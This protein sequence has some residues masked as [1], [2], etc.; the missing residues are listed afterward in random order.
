MMNEVA[1][2]VRPEAATP[3]HSWTE[4]NRQWLIAAIGRLRARIEAGDAERD[5]P[6]DCV[7]TAGLS[8][9]VPALVG[10]AKAFGLSP[11]E[12][13]LL[14]LLAG[15]E[16]DEG[17]R[18][19][20]V[21]AGAGAATRASFSFACAHLIAP[22]WDALSPDAPLRHWRMM[23]PTHPAG[24]AL[25]PLQIDE[26]VLHFIAGIPA[27]DAVLAGLVS[28][29]IGQAAEVEDRPLVK[30]VAAALESGAIAVL[31]GGE[32]AAGRRD[33]ALAASAA[34]QRAA[35]WIESR[36][37]PGDADALALAARHI[38]REAVLGV[39]TPVLAVQD[40]SAQNALALVS[41]LNAGLIWLGAPVAG[42][43]AL[44]RAR[45]LLRFELPTADISRTRSRLLA[46]WRAVT[47]TD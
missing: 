33:W 30:R 6:V 1:E 5:P 47:G 20:V 40:G 15:L 22:H 36:D 35:L 7:Q 34:R 32:D 12:R 28:Q 21:K 44:P 17:L 41:R 37:L 39:S 18:Q 9:F 2:K 13:E 38:D 26:R 3:L 11:F 24:I 46:R 14:L 29:V 27:S 31:E 42:L 10:L 43:D 8:G 25:A 45:R 4:L 16:L 19:A 23:A